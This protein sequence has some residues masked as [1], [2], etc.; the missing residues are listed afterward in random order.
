MQV[1]FELEK[2][3]AEQL[4]SRLQQSGF[5]ARMKYFKD[6]SKAGY[7][8]RVGG[9]VTKQ[10]AQL[11][12]EQLNKKGFEFWIDKLTDAYDFFNSMRS[13]Q[14]KSFGD[15][16][17]IVEHRMDNYLRS[18]ILLVEP[19]NKRRIIVDEMNNIPGRETW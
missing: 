3:G 17:A 13:E 16:T 15:K 1:G 7:R 10:Q 4:I 6:Q 18:R 11:T 5:H 2:T 9:F 8:I 19:N 12:G 14:Q